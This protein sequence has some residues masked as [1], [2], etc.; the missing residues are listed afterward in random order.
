MSSLMEHVT[1]SRFPQNKPHLIHI[2]TLGG[3]EARGEVSPENEKKSRLTKLHKMALL[4]AVNTTNKAMVGFL[5]M[6][7]SLRLNIV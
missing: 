6:L 4:S 5:I 7:F 1:L 3:T 2:N